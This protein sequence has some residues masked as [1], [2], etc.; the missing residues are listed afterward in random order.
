[1]NELKFIDTPELKFHHNKKGVNARYNKKKF[2]L[3]TLLIGHQNTSFTEKEYLD[4]SKNVLDFECSVRGYPKYGSS[5]NQLIHSKSIINNFGPFYKYVN[6]NIFK[7]KILNGNWQLGNVHQYRTIE[8]IKQRDEFEGFSF[9]NLNINNH[10]VSQVCN[11]GFNYLILCGTQSKNSSNLKEQFGEQELFF[12]D[13]KSFAEDV[14]KEINAIRYFIQK[15]EYNTLKSYY[16]PKV[17]LNPMINVTDNILTPKYF[18]ILYENLIY[19]SLFV[20]PEAFKDENE[21]RIIFEMPKDYNKPY[22]FKNKSLLKHIE[23]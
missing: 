22:K 6:K 15:I 19:P 10:I 7:N 4:S 23:F 17:Y 3:G 16:N 13:V 20:K 21:V 18:D 14:S 11:A 9:L 2:L 5:L 12:P 8:N 1:M